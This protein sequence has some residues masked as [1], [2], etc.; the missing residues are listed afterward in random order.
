MTS[1]YG[2][3]CAPAFA[4]MTKYLEYILNGI[5]VPTLFNVIS[6]IGIL[7][8]SLV[9]YVIVTRAS[10]RTNTNLLL[11]NVATGDLVF[12]TIVPPVTSY[13]F[14]TAR[15]PFGDFAC[16]MMHY[17]CNVISYV[18]VYTLVLVA[19]L[20]YMTIVRD[21][22]TIRFVTQCHT[23]SRS[24]RIKRMIRLRKTRTF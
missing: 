20:R 22:E 8:N 12:V 23:R 16:R 4:M 15:W 21:N 13:V 3:R 17:A 2:D 24:V 1:Q 5:I 10:L 11:L 19:V 14:A 18:T 6:L 7:G 9:I